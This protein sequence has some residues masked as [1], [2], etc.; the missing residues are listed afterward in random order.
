MNFIDENVLGMLVAAYG[1]SPADLA[2]YRSDRPQATPGELLIAVATDWF[3]RIPAL[4]VAEA[5]AGGP[6]RTHVYEFAWPSPQYDGRLGACHGLEVPFVFDTLAAPGSDALTGSAPP[7]ELADAVHGA[8][9]AFV[10]TGDPGWPAYD[11]GA[12]P[13]QVFGTLTS[14]VPD[15]R[16]AQRELWEDVRL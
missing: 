16:G 4:R 6:A 11:L 14:V 9:V 5:R 2:P 8:W 3:F 10:T 7:Q 15:P 13:T 12:R 1:L